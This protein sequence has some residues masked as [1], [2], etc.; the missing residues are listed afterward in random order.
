MMHA[1]ILGPLLVVAIV[2][3]GLLAGLFFVFSIA[4][5]PG[6]RRVDDGTYVQAFQAINAAILNGRFLTVFFVAPIA[7]VVCVV[8]HISRGDSASL[9][10]LVAGAVCSALTFGI[11][12]ARNVPLNQELDSAPI[13]TE[14]QRRIARHRFEKRWNRGNLARTVT[15]IGAFIFLAGASVAG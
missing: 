13:D 8:L 14:Y 4:I 3:N 1:L 2:A 5:S 9:T 12:A 6:L 11:T 15:S 7:A 10:S